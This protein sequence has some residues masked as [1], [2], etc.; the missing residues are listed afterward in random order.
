M[1]GETNS[2]TVLKGASQ[3][4]GRAEGGA[5]VADVYLG[6]AEQK[7]RIFCL[8]GFVEDRGQICILQADCRASFFIC[9][10]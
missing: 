2:G 3:F 6:A 9:L 8:P 1:N 10:C 4:L 5:T 7:V